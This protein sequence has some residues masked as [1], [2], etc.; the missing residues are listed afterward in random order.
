MVSWSFSVR[1]LVLVC[2]I[3]GGWLWRWTNEVIIV[4]ACVLSA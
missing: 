3:F 4:V 2:L 1:G